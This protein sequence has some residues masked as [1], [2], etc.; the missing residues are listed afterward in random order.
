MKNFKHISKSEIQ[1]S[2]DTHRKNEDDPISS[3]CHNELKENFPVKSKWMR[4]K[5]FFESNFQ[6]MWYVEGRILIL[7]ISIVKLYCYFF[8][9]KIRSTNLLPLCCW[10]FFTPPLQHNV[11]W[12]SWELYV[13][14]SSQHQ[15]SHFN[16]TQLSSEYIFF[17]CW[18]CLNCIILSSISYEKVKKG[19]IM[20]IMIPFFC[21]AALSFSASLL[22]HH[23]KNVQITISVWWKFHDIAEKNQKKILFW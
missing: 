22:H 10:C 23:S 2:F 16:W 12:L 18:K 8:V 6:L 13:V 1:Q 19:Q 4:R 7:K 15:Q 3:R 20:W 14:A 5:F 11:L 21:F 17:F 9:Q